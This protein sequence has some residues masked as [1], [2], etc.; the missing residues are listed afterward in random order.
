LL[1]HQFPQ[2][3]YKIDALILSHFYINF[4]ILPKSYGK[5]YDVSKQEGWINLGLSLLPISVQNG[6]ELSQRK[7]ISNE[8]KA[9]IG[10]AGFLGVK[11]DSREPRK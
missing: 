5:S 3:I 1:Y 10:L 2:A 8:Q 11:I 7:D 6:Q 9:A 4:S